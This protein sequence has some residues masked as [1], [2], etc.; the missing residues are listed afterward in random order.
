[1]ITVM[2]DPDKSPGDDTHT[3]K[4]REVSLRLDGPKTS[5]PALR[6]LVSCH[7]RVVFGDGAL[8]EYSYSVSIRQSVETTED[9]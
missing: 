4:Y 2:A 5:A 9:T 7:G 8:S 3:T 6:W 1:M